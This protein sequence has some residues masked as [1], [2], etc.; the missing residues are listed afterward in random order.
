M[1][2]LALPKGS[3]EKATLQLFEDADLP[4]NRSTDRDYRPTVDDPRITE[5]RIL[6]PQE[7]PRYVAEGLFDLGIAG[8]DWIEESGADVVTLTE[9]RYSKVS[10]RPVRIVVAVPR[11]S[12]V[13]SV[14]DLRDGIRVSTELPNLTE[15]FFADQGIKA[16]IRLSYG[17]TEAKVPDIVDVIVELTETGSSLRAAGLKIVG[18]IMTSYTE[19]FANPASYEDLDKR[20]AMEQLTT[21]LTGTLEARGRVLVK[22]NVDEAKLEDV[23]AILPAM[24]APTIN[25]LYGGNAYAVEAVVPKTEINILIPALK[26]HGATDIIELPIAK[27]V[28]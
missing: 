18:E 10:Q 6:R 22:L 5:V 16:D 11:E 13:E 3:L 8:R 4:V 1:L 7:I 27:I 24:K 23:I 9:L 26:E 17:A 28:H 20:R 19:L 25:Q 2:R 12:P 21:L 14:A 15:R